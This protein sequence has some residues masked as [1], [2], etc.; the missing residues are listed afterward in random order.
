[1]AD[2]NE[3]SHK[4]S[5]LMQQSLKKL[6]EGDIEGSKKDMEEAIK[7][8]NM[9]YASVESE[10]GK[11]TQLYGE[12]RNFGMMYN[13]FEQNIDKLLQTKR[14]KQ[15]IKEGYDLIKRNKILNEEFKIYDLFEKSKKQDNTKDF[16]NEAVSLIKKFNKKQIKENNDKFIMFIRRNKLNEY[17]EIPEETENLYEAIEYV[18]LNNKDINN[19]ENFLKAKNTIVE[20]IER[21][22]NVNEQKVSFNKFNETLKKEET[23]I[24]E[25]INDEERKLINMFTDKKTNKREIFENLKRNTLNKLEKMINE[26]DESD[27]TSWKSIYKD[28]TSKTFSEKLS[29]NIV[30]C[31]EMMEICN[32]IE[33]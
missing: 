31:A 4:G 9:F 5:V 26:S 19:V 27:K 10:E 24:D 11:I 28:I 13:V 3:Y 7:Y 16:V 6:E 2:F 30:N 29:E 20:H 25:N 21:N 32:T 18:I 15:V 22:E 23:E 33:E 8:F 1:M 14:G 12:S 17:V